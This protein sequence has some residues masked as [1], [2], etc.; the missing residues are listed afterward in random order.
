MKCVKMKDY[1][2]AMKKIEKTDFTITDSNELAQTKYR[3]LTTMLNNKAS[4][5]NVVF[6]I[7]QEYSLLVSR[8]YAPMSRIKELYLVEGKLVKIN[9]KTY[10][11][12]NKLIKPETIE[13]VII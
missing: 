8:A 6:N 1:L 12:D 4:N 5:M 10:Q 13:Y 9:D 11:I 3:L 2:L 7:F